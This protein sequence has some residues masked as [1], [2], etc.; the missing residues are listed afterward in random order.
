MMGTGAQ[1]VLQIMMGAGLA[2]SAGLRAWLPLLCAQR[3]RFAGEGTS[4]R[5]ESD[6]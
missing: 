4:G 6:G 3:C 5:D 1:I 2:A